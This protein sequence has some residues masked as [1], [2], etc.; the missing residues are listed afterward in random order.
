MLPKLIFFVSSVVL[1][2][3]IFCNEISCTLYFDF[4]SAINFL[5][6]P[7]SV[8]FTF[9]LNLGRIGILLLGLVIFPFS[10]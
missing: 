4:I 1:S 6:V 5:R 8:S 9:N 7:E 3:F 2:A 10:T